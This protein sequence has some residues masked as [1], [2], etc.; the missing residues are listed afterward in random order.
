MHGSLVLLG[1]LHSL[2]CTR[3]LSVALLGGGGQPEKQIDEIPRQIPWRW[4]VP[5]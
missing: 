2:K 1:P 4:G 5:S 3:V